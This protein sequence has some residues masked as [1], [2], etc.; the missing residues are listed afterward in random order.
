MQKVQACEQPSTAG[1]CAEISW[2]RSLTGRINSSSIAKKRRVVSA[3]PREWISPCVKKETK[4]PGSDGGEKTSTYGNLFFSFSLP[5]TPT[6]QPI[7]LITK[8][9]FFSLSGRREVRRP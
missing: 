6:R 1:T 9:G 4:G 2:P 3:F 8:L 7:R 5:R